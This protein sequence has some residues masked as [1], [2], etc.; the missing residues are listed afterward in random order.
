MAKKV[1]LDAV[2]VIDSNDLTEWCAKVELT[3]DFEEKD[4]TT[5]G[6][7]GAKEVLGGLESGN[8]G[9]TFKNS[10]TS[11][12]LDEI[13]WTIA[14]TRTPVTFTVR[15]DEAVVSSGNPQYS[16]SLLVN[17]WMP[18]AGSVGDVN[19]ADYT[20]PLSGALARATST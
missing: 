12:E 7:G 16:G 19:E 11:G 13:M 6:S 3:D 10:H 17:K 14:R 18:I 9:I 8:V 2:L 5:Y 20:F 15:A 1:L 4:T